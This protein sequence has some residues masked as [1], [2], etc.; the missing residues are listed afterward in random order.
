MGKGVVVKMSQMY[1]TEHEIE[2][3]SIKCG[4]G[5]EHVLASHNDVVP[6]L[7][8]AAKERNNIVEN[9]A[10]QRITKL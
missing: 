3:K 4:S 5:R 2:N 8:L 9:R 7:H 10:E 6:L 1:L